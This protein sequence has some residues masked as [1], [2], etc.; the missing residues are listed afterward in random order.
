MKETILEINNLTVVY[1]ENTTNE[2]IAL[3]NFSTK[4]VRG[5]KVLIAGDNGSGKSTLLNAI[6]GII[7]IKE[8]QIFVRGTNITK[9]SHI[10][11][12]KYF[13]YVHQDILL[14]TCPNL[15]LNENLRATQPARWW[16]PYPYKLKLTCEEV[17]IFNEYCDI[18]QGRFADKINTFSGGQRQA[19][20]VFLNL[21]SNKPIMLLDEYVSAL[22]EHIKERVIDYT[23]RKI[24]QKGITAL[25]VLHQNSHVSNYS[26]QISFSK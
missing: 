10:K 6:A 2:I 12:S 8:G 20:V 9:W 15:S 14:G 23:L 26:T 17:K 1:N 7:P 16:L 11:R 24:D 13:S 25:F 3:D 21:L 4:I 19:L 18:F 5:E 22:D